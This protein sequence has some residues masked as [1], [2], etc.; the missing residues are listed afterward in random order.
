MWKT[1]STNNNT[2][3]WD[4]INK[5]VD[6]YNNSRH[7]SIKMKPVEESEKENEEKTFV[8]LY[9]DLIYLKSKIPK[10][11][12]GHRVRISKYKRR[13]FDKGY[14]PTWTEQVFVVNEVLPTK[15]VTYK[16]VD[17]MGE[18]IEELK[19]LFTSKSYKNQSKKYLELRKFEDEITRKS[20]HW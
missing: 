12:I 19:A 8:N 16:I 4:K 5:L 18:E 9:G 17:L 15:P 7:S 20:W 10:F 1:F 13:V 11:A 14:T 2:V 3:Y 6:D